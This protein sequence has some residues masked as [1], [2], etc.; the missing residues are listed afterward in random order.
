MLNGKCLS[1]DNSIYTFG[2]W[3]E[4]N[5]WLRNCRIKRQQWIGHQAKWMSPSFRNTCSRRSLK[6]ED[7]NSTQN[8]TYKCVIAHIQQM[9]CCLGS[10][11]NCTTWI[12]HQGRCLSV[13]TK[14][15]CFIWYIICIPVKRVMLLSGCFL[16]NINHSL[17]GGPIQD[18]S[19]D[20]RMNYFF[21]VLYLQLDS[22]QPYLCKLESGRNF[23][24]PFLSVRRLTSFS[25]IV[26]FDKRELQCFWVMS[27]IV[28]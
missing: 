15:L 26:T 5:C 13:H 17:R 22:C 12:G 20:S 7:C 18:R 11:V 10:A 2:N 1:T 9:C 16:L 19:Y 3:V 23:C 24:L 25:I 14:L 27:T 6:C 21:S 8:I 28:N 4:G